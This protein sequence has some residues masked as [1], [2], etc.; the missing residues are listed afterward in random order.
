MRMDLVRQGFVTL[1]HLQVCQSSL[2]VC[3][4]DGC[5]DFL[6]STL[7]KVLSIAF[8]EA[9]RPFLADCKSVELASE[10]KQEGCLRSTLELPR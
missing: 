6:R 1:G 3:G 5:R 8:V 9:E 4:P 10:P 2:R 7:R